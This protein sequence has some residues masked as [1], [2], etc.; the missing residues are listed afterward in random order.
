MFYQYVLNS[1]FFHCLYGHAPTT[2]TKKW[3]TPPTRRGWC[4]VGVTLNM[5]W[6]SVALCQWG[7]RVPVIEEWYMDKDTNYVHFYGRRNNTE[8]IPF[9]DTYIYMTLSSRSL[10]RYSANANPAAFAETVSN[11]GSARAVDV[12]SV[13]RR[14]AAVLS[15]R[16]SSRQIVYDWWWDRGNDG[17]SC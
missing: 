12:H 17:K 5:D 9:V 4:G 7:V 13:I 15:T 3:N 16:L 14:E 6:I 8:K 2:T 10:F 1:S 11:C